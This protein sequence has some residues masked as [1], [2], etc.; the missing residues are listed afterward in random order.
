[1]VAQTGASNRA[2]LDTYDFGRFGTVCDVGGGYG[3]LL[4][5]LLETYP[6]MQGILFDQPHVVANANEVLSPVAERCRV[7]A[8]DFFESV[9]GGADAYVLRAIIHDWDDGEATRIL[10]ACGRGMNGGSLLV[11]E[12]IVGDANEDPATKFSDLNML[13]SPGGRERTVDEFRRLFAAGG[14]ELRSVTET[15]SGFCVIEGT[16]DPQSS[17]SPPQT[18]ERDGTSKL[19]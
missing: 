19:T 14:F 10:R 3:G 13:V 12:R 9:P 2:L 5:P 4:A 1:M 16:P 11:I 6:A 18:A 8:G 7:V 17:S 15:P